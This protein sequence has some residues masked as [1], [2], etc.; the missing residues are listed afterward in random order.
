MLEILNRSGDFNDCF[1][2][3]DGKENTCLSES[4]MQKNISLPR[5]HIP[6]LAFGMIGET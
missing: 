2:A 6:A 3:S 5:F 1:A 4:P